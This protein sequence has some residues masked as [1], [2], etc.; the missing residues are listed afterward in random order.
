M[1]DCAS[2]CVNFAFLAVS[3][4]PAV[5]IAMPRHVLNVAS[6]N[7]ANVDWDDV[8]LAPAWRLALAGLH[9]HSNEGLSAW[10]FMPA[11]STANRSPASCRSSP[12]AI[13]ERAEFPLH[14]I[15]ARFLSAM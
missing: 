15:S 5:I 12:S 2:N 13:C 6:S 10:N 8:D 3:E 9:R 1:C 11:L 4:G 14:R 7:D